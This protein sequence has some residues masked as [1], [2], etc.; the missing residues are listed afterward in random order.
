LG[1]DGRR[2]G[3]GWIPTAARLGSPFG[4]LRTASLLVACSN[5]LRRHNSNKSVQPI[6]KMFA[7]RQLS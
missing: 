5:I 7:D 6:P 3:G 1:A 4:R 2:L